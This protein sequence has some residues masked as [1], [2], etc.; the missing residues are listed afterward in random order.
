MTSQMFRVRELFGYVYRVEQRKGGHH[1]PR[2]P[3]N[4]RGGGGNM[5]AGD[6]GVLF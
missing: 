6:W 4:F 5:F 1:K 3:E 2:N